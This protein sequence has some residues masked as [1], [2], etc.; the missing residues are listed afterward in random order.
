MAN[1]EET[2]QS[3]EFK[4]KKTGLIAFGVI[5][6]IF[7][8]FCALAIP[9]MILGMLASAA[10]GKSSAAPMS[11]RMMV[12]G[13][14]FYALLA[15]W[16]I[17][18]GIGS[19]KAR[20][21]ARA[22]ILVSSSLWLICGIGGLIF[23][24]LFLPGMYDQMAKNPQMPPAAVSIMKFTMIGFMTVFYVVIPAVFV[25]FY[26]SK[27]VKATCEF[28]D[29]QVRW[30]DKCPLPVLAVSLIFGLW[31]ASALFTGFYKW[32]FPFFGFILSGIPG[33]AV[34][35]VI[36]LLSAY[37]AWGTYR[38]DIKAWWCS[39]LLIIALALSTVITFSR[40]SIWDLYEKM[41]FPKEQMDM[42]RQYGMPQ[43]STMAVLVGLWSLGL[44]AYLLYIRR[45][46]VSPPDQESPSQQ[47]QTYV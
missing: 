19:I 45:Y 13:V 1:S 39:L 27:N 29:P 34:A 17:W 36:M 8:G 35:L 2:M 23:M 7:G 31:A 18:M 38:L 15:V 44:L 11:G 10:L 40:V 33:A 37:N 46:F 41:N 28:R 14:L 9:F 43:T 26:K 16:F 20:R 12:P 6:I 4:D 42:M 22:L 30:T 3:S 21:W 32:T 47:T 24:L 5:Q 25:L